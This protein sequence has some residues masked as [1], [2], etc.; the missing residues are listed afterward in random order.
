VLCGSATSVGPD[1]A[2]PAERLF[3]RMSDKTLWPFCD[4]GVGVTDGCFP[5]GLSRLV[6]GGMVVRGVGYGRVVNWGEGGEGGG[7]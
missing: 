5:E 1:F 6:V 4:G 7:E 2:N 3:C